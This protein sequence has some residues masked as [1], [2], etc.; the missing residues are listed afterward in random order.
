MISIDV[1]QRQRQFARTWESPRGWAGWIATVNSR[2]LGKRYMITALS[3]FFVGVLLA[4]AIRTQLAVPN[5]TFLTPDLYNGV[6]TMHGSTM[7]YLF[8]VPFIEGM[9]IYLIPML[10][11]SR[12]LAFPRLTN[13]GYWSYLFGGL[14]MYAAILFGAVPDAGWT[15]YPPLAGPKHSGIGL[16][17]WLLGLGMV[18]IAGITAAVEIVVTILKLRAPG[19]AV[20]HVPILVWAYVVTGVMIIFAFTPLLIATFL[21]EM[22]RSVGTQFFNPQRGGSSLLWQHLFWWFGHPEVYIIFLPATGMISA[23]IPVFARRRLVAYPLVIAAIISTG[24]VSFGLWSHH[25][26]TTGIPDLPMHFFALERRFPGMVHRLSAA[27]LRIRPAAG[28]PRP[29]PPMVQAPVGFSG[30]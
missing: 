24:F 11:G 3:F 4:L 20:Q 16:D 6:F 19:M 8:A 27:A 28:R 9:G 21:L 26:F 2:P 25:M 12:D 1:E 5:N 14:T 10:I 29:L 30:R 13:F 23:I 22:D 17:F 15:A 7:L 18:E